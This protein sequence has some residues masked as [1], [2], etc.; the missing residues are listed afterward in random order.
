V[1]LRRALPPRPAPP[2]FPYTTLFRSVGP[3]YV[4]G[5]ESSTAQPTPRTG[6]STH[7]HASAVVTGYVP[8]ANVSDPLRSGMRKPDTTRAGTRS[9]EHTS[10]L[11][12]RGHL[13]CRL[14]REKN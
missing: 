2:L 11:Q 3:A 13:V 9:E 8:A 1:E 7:V 10:E 4:P 6:I 12:S 5:D 14:L